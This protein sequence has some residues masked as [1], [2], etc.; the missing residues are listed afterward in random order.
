VPAP[1]PKF[2]YNTDALPKEIYI[3]RFGASVFFEQEAL[4]EGTEGF[5]LKGYEKLADNSR[6]EL[7]TTS[8]Q[9]YVADRGSREVTPETIYNV[10]EVEISLAD[11]A[12]SRED[13]LKGVVSGV[14]GAV[15]SALVGSVSTIVVTNIVLGGPVYKALLEKKLRPLTYYV[16]EG[17]ARQQKSYFM[18]RPE[19]KTDWS[20][21]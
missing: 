5:L 4:P 9:P 7:I 6:Q 3:G 18:Y 17:K 10:A 15:E 13:F 19:K 8:V 11:S 14:V 12:D 21:K 20:L 1:R 2:Q 16:G